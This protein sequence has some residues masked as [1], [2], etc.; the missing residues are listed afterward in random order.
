MRGKGIAGSAAAASLGITPAYAGKSDGLRIARSWGLGSPPRM[1]GKG[2]FM[3]CASRH[4]GITP[5]YAGKS[6]LLVFQSAVNRDHPRVCGEKH[7]WCWRSDGNHG[8]PPRMRGKE[9]GWA[10]RFHYRRITPAYAGKRTRAQFLSLL[11]RD[12]PRV[13]GEK[14]SLEIWGCWAT[15]SPPRMRGKD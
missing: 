6:I 7:H 15:G 14:D 9:V 11:P 5:A 8:S 2:R 1:R 4:R 3:K 12:H 13:C 10:G